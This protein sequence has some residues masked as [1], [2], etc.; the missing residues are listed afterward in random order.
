VSITDHLRTSAPIVEKYKVD[1]FPLCK[2][3]EIG[4]FM[5]VFILVFLELKLLYTFKPRIGPK[6]LPMSN[7]YHNMAKGTLTSLPNY[8]A[9]HSSL[10]HSPYS[11]DMSLP[12]L[13]GYVV[14]CIQGRPGF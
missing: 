5:N 14:K 1:K 13:H 10:K 12:V 6:I 8:P 9:K 3:I 7:F 4:R 11:Q 2:K